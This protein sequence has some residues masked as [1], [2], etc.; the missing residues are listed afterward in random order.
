M[1]IRK[2]E[3]FMFLETSFCASLQC[4]SYHVLVIGHDGYNNER[5]TISGGFA[6]FLLFFPVPRA[7]LPHVTNTPILLQVM[8]F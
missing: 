7:V 6:F 4:D 1:S 3:V 5:D 2:T 8:K